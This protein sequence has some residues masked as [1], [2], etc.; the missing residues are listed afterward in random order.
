MENNAIQ[1]RT[2]QKDDISKI[3]IAFDEPI[4][5]DNGFVK[6]INRCCKENE[7]RERI[8]FVAF[9]NN[10]VAG[11]VNIIYKSSYQYFTEKNIPELNDLRVL[12]KYRRNGIGKM[13]V[14][15]CEKYA[16]S[17]YEYIGLGVG[18]YK[19]Y[20]SAQKLYTKNGYVLDGN[21]LMYNNIEVKPGK[22][23]FVDDDLLLYL[24]KKL[25]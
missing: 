1:I 9:F 24:Y 8:T 25:R 10:E 23:V 17:K 13:L 18:L 3:V 21:G 15:E 19:D 2:L 11:Y 6:Y 20:G 7:T 16:S 12:A 4:G 5:S 22:D 14:N